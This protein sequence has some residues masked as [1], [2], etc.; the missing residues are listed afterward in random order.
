MVALQGPLGSALE[1]LAPLL[2]GGA[3]P[4]AALIPLLRAS[5]AVLTVSHLNLMHIQAA[6]EQFSSARILH[7]VHSSICGALGPLAQANSSEIWL[8]SLPCKFGTEIA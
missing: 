3:V 2:S 4:A 5:A 8:Q 6:G 7:I 1:L